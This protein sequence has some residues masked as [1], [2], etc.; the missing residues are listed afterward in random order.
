M[1]R[2]NFI[3][4]PQAWMRV[5][6]SARSDADYACSIE[7]HEQPHGYSWLWWLCM[8]LCAVAGA[9]AIVAGG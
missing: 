3:E 1:K 2:R 4:D 5:A 9:V 7:K 8:V 6:R